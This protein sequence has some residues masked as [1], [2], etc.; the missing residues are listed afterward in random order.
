M[1]GQEITI[2]GAQT[3]SGSIKISG[4]KNATLPLMTACLLTEKKVVLENVPDITDVDEMTKQLGSYGVQVDK[5]DS[6]RVLQA[7]RSQT[8]FSP[9]SSAG[10]KTRASFLVLGPL[11]ARFKAAKVY[12]PGGCQIGQNGRPVNFHIDALEQMKATIE[13]DTEYVLLK[14]DQGLQGAEIEFPKISVGATQTVVMAACLAKGETV[15]TN[16]AVEPEVID[17]I[18]MLNEMGMNGDIRV[19]KSENKIIINGRNRILLNGCT[20]TVIPGKV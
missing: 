17:L 5:R 9:T 20:H 4:A 7:T 6:R 11:L 18:E 2:S 19:D 8:S 10:S 12:Y 13:Q 1:A 14:A 3:C 16:A 15:I